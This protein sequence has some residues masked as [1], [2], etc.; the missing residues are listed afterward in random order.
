MGTALTNP[1]AMYCSVPRM[2]PGAV[3]D[4]VMVVAAGATSFPSATRARPKSS[5]VACGLS[6]DPS[7]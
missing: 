1:G 5:S 6:F 4:P 2:A 3:I 7:P